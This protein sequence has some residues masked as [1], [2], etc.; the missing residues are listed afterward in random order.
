M[1]VI[2]HV[3][4]CNAVCNEWCNAVCNESCYI[5]YYMPLHEILHACYMT[6]KI[7][8]VLH[9]MACN[10]H[11]ITCHYMHYMPLHAIEDANEARSPA[12]DL[13]P[14]CSAPGR[15]QPSAATRTRWP[16]VRRSEA[17]PAA[18][19]AARRAGG[20]RLRVNSFSTATVRVCPTVCQWLFCQSF[21]SQVYWLLEPW[22]EVWSRPVGPGW[23]FWF[24]FNSAKWAHKNQ[25]ILCI[26]FLQ[27]AGLGAD[28]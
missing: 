9:V 13:G 10:W 8:E 22:L 25:C 12:A 17:G 20:S 16:T 3:I 1:H 4:V 5:A 15:D 7:W 27:E 21:K 19:R 28:F 18:G 26:F 2:L 24:S 11:V 14:Q 23:G 6:L